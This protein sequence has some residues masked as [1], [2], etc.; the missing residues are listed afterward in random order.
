M[1]QS[2]LCCLARLQVKIESNRSCD[3]YN[4]R[5]IIEISSV[6]PIARYVAQFRLGPP[7]VDLGGAILQVRLIV[8][9][10]EK[11]PAAPTA[12]GRL[13]TN[14]WLAARETSG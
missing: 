10:G 8:F 13:P 3:A 12:S 2:I 11:N 6:P 7:D 4:P 5:D 9:P 1:D 14:T